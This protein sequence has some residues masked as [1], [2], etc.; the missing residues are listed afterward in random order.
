MPFYIRVNGLP[1]WESG[2]YRL[3][4]AAEHEYSRLIHRPE[5]L[6]AVRLLQTKVQ[7]IMDEVEEETR[8]QIPEEYVYKSCY[9]DSGFEVILPDAPK[10]KICMALTSIHHAEVIWWKS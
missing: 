9:P 4:I 5:V 1:Q 10:K 6:T 3:W 2:P 7:L 8:G